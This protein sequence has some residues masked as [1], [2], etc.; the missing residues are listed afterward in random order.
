M[1]T[2]EPGVPG[3][4]TAFPLLNALI[5]AAVVLLMAEPLKS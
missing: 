3:C 5:W 4:Q 1:G 2:K